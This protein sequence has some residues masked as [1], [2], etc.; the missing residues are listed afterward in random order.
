MISYIFPPLGSGANQRTARFVKYLGHFGWTP[1]VLTVKNGYYRYRDDYFLKIIPD[2]VKIYRAFSLEPARLEPYTRPITSVLKSL[3]RIFLRS[4]AVSVISQAGD[5][6]T[7]SVEDI[8]GDRENPSPGVRGL[9]MKLMR[10]FKTYILIPDGRIGWLPFAVLMG[11]K[12]IYRERPSVIWANADT[13]SDLLIGCCLKKITRRKL[14]LNFSDPW[15]LN[16]YYP[17]DHK[18][19]RGHIDSLLERIVISKADRIVFATQPM[20]CDYEKEYKDESSKFCMILNG[21]DPDE[22]K[23]IPS[24]WNGEKFI[25]TYCGSLQYFR[26]PEPF[27][28][29]VEGLIDQYPGILSTLLVRFVGKIDHDN[30]R[31]FESFKYKTMLHLTGQVSYQESLKYVLQSDACL[32]IGATKLLD[33]ELPGKVFEFM[34]AKKPILV[35]SQKIAVAKLVEELNVGIVVSP[36]NVHSIQ[37]A[38]LNLI[39][40]RS[41]QGYYK[42]KE[43]L[44]EI[45]SRKSLTGELAACF[46]DLLR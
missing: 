24:S 19:L 27:L 18:S 28:K 31:Y 12:I 38:I 34:A 13:P 26:S 46:D 3:I 15:V 37:T 20:Q 40:G 32:V 43:R 30:L 8:I 2:S 33:W 35:I 23:E 1:I 11:V 7:I 14:V 10:M 39:E 16:A 44:I 25:L 21:Y 36:D 17:F 42:D 45:Y 6:P 9:Y 4:K 29:A 5:S 41:D 22:F